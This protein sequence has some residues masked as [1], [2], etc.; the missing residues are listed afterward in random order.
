MSRITPGQIR[1]AVQKRADDILEWTQAL[2]RLP[3]EN[4]PPLGGEGAAQQFVEEECAGMGWEVD[5]FAPDEVPGIQDHPSWLAGRDY[6][7]ERK[8]V[9]ARW[10]GKGG[11]KSGLFSSHVDVA[12]FEPDDWKEC[13]PY[14]PVV[15][16]GRLYGRGSADMKGSMG[17]AFW[18]LR[19]LR[20]LGFEPEG[21]ILFESVVDEE[22]AGGN[23]TLAA[24]LRGHNADLAVIG[25]P[26]RMEVCPACLGAFLGDLTLSGKAGMPFMG[27]AIANPIHG[28]ARI[29]ELFSEWQERWRAQNAHP[30]F[31][32]PGKELNA[33]L[34]RID[35]TKPG[36]FTQMGTPLLAKVSWIVWCHP[37]MTEPEFYSRF[38]AFWDE[39]AAS[40][41]ALAPFD[42]LIEPDYHFIKPW[43]TASDAPAVQAVVAA[44][45]QYA[46]R[47]PSIGGA[48]FSCDLAVYGEVGNMPCVLLGPRGDNL[49]APDEWCEIED[50]LSLTG[51]YASLAA[52]WGCT[53]ST[54]AGAD[55]Q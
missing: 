22:F 2:I 5:V 12:P 42:L 33:L 29:V 26:T 51:I 8:N 21:D 54:G 48:S 34:W 13:R 18:A 17:A 37:G 36:E 3:S 35:S 16:D 46:G 20:D 25:E 52:D 49:H 43:E 23:G 19:I 24:R 41:P 44:C 32:E 39:H 9:V 28:A 40:D 7:T 11:G 10:P 14:D 50:L 4:R 31:T 47:K 6:G 55:A 30:L 38:R 27:S 45:E 1:E 15:K 53:P